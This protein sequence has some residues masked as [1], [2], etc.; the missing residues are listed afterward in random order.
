H[1]NLLAAFL[2]GLLPL[3]FLAWP[4]GAAHRRSKDRLWIAAASVVA[5]AA[6]VAS[7][8]LG[9]LAALGAL[10]LF[11]LPSLRSSR[12]RVG[13]AGVLGGLAVLAGGRLLAIGRG[14]DTSAHA[15]LGYLEAGWQGWLER[16]LVG[17][18]P[19]ASAWTLGLH[20]RA[21][22]EVR[23]PGQVVA[24]LHS[25]PAGILYELG[26]LGVLGFLGLCGGILAALSR[27]ARAGRRPSP[28]LA[29]AGAW[30]TIGT[31]SGLLMSV[32]AL[33]V[34]MATTLGVALAAR[35]G[36]RATA[37][38]LPVRR[39]LPSSLQRFTFAVGTTALAL[40][41]GL[42]QAPRDLAHLLAGET[43]EPQ[44][45]QRAVELDPDMPLYR[46]RVA[47]RGPSDS[48]A[49]SEAAEAALG[50]APLWLTAGLDPTLDRASRIEALRRACTL[51]PLGAM[52]PWHLAWLVD[53]GETATA[54][55]A[56]ALLLEPRLLASPRWVAEDRVDA[57]SRAAA[58][59]LAAAVERVEGL[60]SI[61]EGWRAAFVERAEEVALLRASDRTAAEHDRKMAR[62][63]LSTD[64]VEALS[65]SLH[66]FRRPAVPIVLTE[67]EV[68][69]ALAQVIDL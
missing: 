29:S 34:G 64:E 38:S 54:S 35:R 68:D 21:D 49:S 10:A 60:L 30:L 1:H 23:P 52:G 56:R 20:L 63:V 69:L 45:L 18:G 24:D 37:D 46:F 11:I 2:V 25:L 47:T 28:A 7:R 43:L 17:W 58:P 13:L 6:V 31:V 15:R 48:Q 36:R 67:V 53:D 57:A 62:L 16:P 44:K 14:L 40:A 19:G 27:S 51:D 61:E 8:S 33:A 9:G 5:V 32:P 22:P 3:A 59:D 12:Q 39:R 41:L 50:L 55:A 65:M 42:W 66:A 4:A 26:L